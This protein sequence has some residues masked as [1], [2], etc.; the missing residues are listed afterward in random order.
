[1][2]SQMAP[3]FYPPMLQAN[4]NQMAS[5][6]PTYMPLSAGVDSNIGVPSP[7]G[8]SST[9]TV[10]LRVTPPLSLAPNQSFLAEGNPN[11]NHLSYSAIPSH[12]LRNIDDMICSWQ[13]KLY[14]ERTYWHNAQ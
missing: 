3:A 7:V 9:A 4:T 11:T 13:K 5:T 12:Q 2:G 6:L 14:L 8:I 10:P 1:M